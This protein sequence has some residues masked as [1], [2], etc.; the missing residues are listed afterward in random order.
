MKTL[1]VALLLALFC[2]TAFAQKLSNSD[3]EALLEKLE[4]IREEADSRVDARFSTAIA[5]YRTAMA[6]GDAAMDLYLLCEE[7]VNFDEM[8][9]KGS[10]FRDWKKNNA[11]K[12]SDKSFREALCVQLR[13]LVLT[14]E[15]SSEDPDL[16]KLSIEASKL[17]E[18]I[19]SQAEDFFPH[20]N[21][22][23][24]G[25][26]ST[27]FARA[28]DIN[29]TK[30]EKWPLSPVPVAAVYEQVIL[31]CLR[32]PDRITA[33]GDAWD[34]RMTQ[35]STLLDAWDG[36]SD[37][38]GKAGQRGPAYE[39]FV[40]ETIPKLRWERELDLF[41]NGDER[42]AALRMLNHIE[43]NLSHASASEWA[44]K[45]TGL[46]QVAPTETP[47]AQPK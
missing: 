26:T 38:K 7:K 6:S 35:E 14:L 12:F 4:K 41:N 19:V 42:A 31:P 44:E 30:A 23:Q 21:V 18:A 10:D 36:D 11:D 39:K 8:Q 33:L 16:D 5:A 27:V 15:A 28:Y 45:F 22:L 2:P 24:Q 40:S 13:W 32:R 17:L 43:Q 20:R 47:E 34:R 46:L 9:K 25:V 29:G 1:S 3:R 37:G